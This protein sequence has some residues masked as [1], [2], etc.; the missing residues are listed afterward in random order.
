[1]Q[2][3]A[4]LSKPVAAVDGS[5]ICAPE[6]S[7]VTA[8]PLATAAALFMGNSAVFRSI[9]LDRALAAHDSEQICSY[10]SSPARSSSQASRVNNCES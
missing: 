5:R 2:T 9:H 8:S 1:M 6:E 3:I 7:P 10:P 4:G